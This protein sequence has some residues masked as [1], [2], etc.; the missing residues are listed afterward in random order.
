MESRRKWN[1][2]RPANF[3]SRHT[4]PLKFVSLTV[5]TITLKATRSAWKV[6]DV[7]VAA[8]SHPYLARSITAFVAPA[9]TNQPLLY[10]MPYLLKYVKQLCMLICIISGSEI[11]DCFL[12]SEKVLR[13]ISLRL[14]N[15][16]RLSTLNLP[17]GQRL[18]T[19][20]ILVQ[21]K[22]RLQ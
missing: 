14:R 22:V 1:T 20:L 8:V 12:F 5:A 11:E 10:S 15:V 4:A 16:K 21:S 19:E 7:E 18:E 17:K 9:E 13:V 2:K 3:E 6:I